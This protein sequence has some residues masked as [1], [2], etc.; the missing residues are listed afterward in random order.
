MEQSHDEE[1]HPGA[2]A[3]NAHDYF[4]EDF[5]APVPVQQQQ[6]GAVSPSDAQESRDLLL[7]WNE[8]P[9]ARTPVQTEHVIVEVRNLEEF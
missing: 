9:V 1:R 7:D 6:T 3:F 2:G 8:A 4:D 5:G